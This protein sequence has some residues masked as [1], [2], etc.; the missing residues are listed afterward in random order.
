MPFGSHAKRYQHK[1]AL[2][3]KGGNGAW[4]HAR[5]SHQLWDRE[6]EEGGEGVILI[7]DFVFSSPLLLSNPLPPLKPSPAAVLTHNPASLVGITQAATAMPVL[8]EQ[9]LMPSRAAEDYARPPL[10]PLHLTPRPQGPL[11]KRYFALIYSDVPAQK[12]WNV[13][14]GRTLQRA[15]RSFWQNPTER[16]S[17]KAGPD[18]SSSAESLWWE[19]RGGAWNPAWVSLFFL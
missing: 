7:P 5:S 15:F 14:M 4:K 16:F 2:C 19:G 13:P 8:L 11:E 18:I 6:E 1:E 12:R 17:P 3:N 10:P 9:P